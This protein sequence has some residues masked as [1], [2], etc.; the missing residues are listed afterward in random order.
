MDGKIALAEIGIASLVFRLAVGA[1]SNQAVKFVVLGFGPGRL[2]CMTGVV[3]QRETGLN[4]PGN[5]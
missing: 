1:G 4:G 3:R 2:I 5:S